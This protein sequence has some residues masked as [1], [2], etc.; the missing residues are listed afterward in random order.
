MVWMDVCEAEKGLQKH[1]AVETSR[2]PLVPA[3]KCN[4]VT[5]RPKTREI[6]SRYKS[7]TPPSTPSG[8]RRY[9]SPN[10][11]RTV[12][13]PTHLAPK[14]A[15]S[16]ERKRPSTPPSPPS[17]STP[18]RDSTTDM[19]SSSRRMSGRLQESLWPSTM[20]SLSVSF[21]SDTFSL[22]IGKRE[23]P[24]VTHAAYDRTLK[25][26]SNVAHKQVETSAAS[27]K[28]T[29]D[30]KRSP[31]KGKNGSDHSENSKPVEGL[32]AR[33][34][35]QH[36]WPSRIGGKVS[37]NS[38]TKSMDLSDKPVK[39]LPSSGIGVS[40]LRRM[41]M[42]DSVNKLLARSA[43]D[44]MTE[45]L[46][47]DE[48]GSAGSEA[49][50][51]DDNPLRV[52]EQPKPFSLSSFDRMA[53]K[54]RT[55]R[56]H[57]IPGSRPASP[58]KTTALSSSISRGMVSPSST[59]PSTP[60]RPSTPTRPPTPTRPSTP[61]SARSITSPSRIRLSSPSHQ[62]TSSASV[63]GFIADFRKGKKS[64]NHIEDAHQLRLLYNRNLQ[65]LYANARADDA[66]YIQKE[67]AEV[68]VLIFMPLPS[69]LM[70]IKHLSCGIYHIM[71][72]SNVLFP[73]IGFP[74][75][76]TMI[77]CIN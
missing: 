36:R 30:R 23:K 25:P 66:L 2:R 48:S 41:P 52:P 77:L 43:S 17:L 54:N 56:T 68:G 28:P 60:S 71:E 45:L 11:T 67:T 34:I 38:L 53:A 16:A 49:N 69:F 35:D 73:F 33:L 50:P 64:G 13:V 18:A 24:S 21:Q 15:Q 26:S 14:R 44:A 63:L 9:N 29:L 61:T 31:L 5:G 4:G 27:R 65:W 6:R 32:H 3:E 8:P 7:P 22:P 37:S 74:T 55:M 46:S 12:P 20:R 42:S 70:L 58:N 47:F 75:V 72:L 59:R 40:L 10:L 39:T 62:L 19:H 76:N 51:I 57:C 1:T